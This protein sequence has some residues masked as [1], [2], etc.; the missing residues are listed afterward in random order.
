[1]APEQLPPQR[2]D[3]R[4]RHSEGGGVLRGKLG[5]PALKAGPSAHIP[6][7]SRIY[8]SGGGPALNV[9]RCALQLPAA[10]ARSFAFVYHQGGEATASATQVERS[11]R[12]RSDEEAP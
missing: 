11:L 10:C 4:V 7:G 6:D 1:M 9:Y 3:R 2:F 12:H 5:L 8:G